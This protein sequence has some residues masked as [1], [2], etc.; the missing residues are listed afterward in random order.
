MLWIHHCNIYSAGEYLLWKM[1]AA[2]RPQSLSAEQDPFL[3]L[4]KYDPNMVKCWDDEAYYGTPLLVMQ[5]SDLPTRG[6]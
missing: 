2:C 5:F 3:C 1:V 6:K 4:L